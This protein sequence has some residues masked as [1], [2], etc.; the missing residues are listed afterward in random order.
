MNYLNRSRSE[1]KL[2]PAQHLSYLGLLVFT[3]AFFLACA[4]YQSRWFD[5]AYTMAMVRQDVFKIIAIT[6]QDVHPPLY[7]LL[8]KAAAFF[9]GESII[10]YRIVSVVGMVL[11]ASLGYT[12]VR[13][14]FDTKTGFYFIFLVTFLPVMLEYSVEARMYSW[15][16]FFTTAAGIYA[17]FAACR[18]RQK[19]YLWLVFFSLCAAYTHYYALLGVIFLNLIFF[20]AS[21]KKGYL[22]QGLLVLAL[23]IILYL[24]WVFILIR[25][26]ISVAQ[27][28]W[29]VINYKYLLRDFS[30]FYFAENLPQTAAM[31]LTY[32][33]F[34]ICA[35]GIAQ[36]VREQRDN[37]RVCFLSIAVY[38]AVIIAA[39]LLSQV[40]PI[41]ITRYLMPNS[42]L[43]FIALAFGLASYRQ[44][45][46][47]YC[48]C[49]IILAAS[50]TN[51]YFNY[52]K[53]YDAEN[54]A[55]EEN[56]AL[57]LKVE[58]IFVYTDIHPAGIY[59]G[60]F[61]NNKHYVYFP[62]DNPPAETKPNPFQPELTIIYNL[63]VLKNY[64]GRIWLLET[65]YA[66]PL[67]GE[68][69]KNEQLFTV[70]DYGRVYN[71]PFLGGKGFIFTT[72]LFQKK[73]GAI[74]SQEAR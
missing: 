10:V 70:L 34:L 48:L 12:Q 8:L 68:W 61:P 32:L 17:Y 67:Y 33:L 56:I 59:S 62:T 44:K 58:D 19:D 57:S 53:I 64:Q 46:A 14:I 27:E 21:F 23:E 38:V 9:F 65:I 55:L 40:K 11:L 66:Q 71:M 72:S 25:Q 2:S 49:L 69:G 15:A 51:F 29:I 4:F 42:G 26:M 50:L 1:H 45:L 20:A 43:L 18:N 73:P 63:D 54:K 60:I 3:A 41:F 37:L 6:S 28:Y 30:V 74:F 39:L 52:H 24:P 5:E 16:I 13:K 47:P 22:K 36:A 31:V 35:L 7:Y